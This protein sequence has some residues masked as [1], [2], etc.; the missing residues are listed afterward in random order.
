M[1]RLL[2]KREKVISYLTLA[3]VIFSIGFNFVLAPI[4]KRIDT[5]NKETGIVRFRLKKYLQLIREKS[6]LE[7]K[8]RNFTSGL[9]LPEQGGAGVSAP[10]ALEAIAKDANIRIVDIRPQNTSSRGVYSESIIDVRTEGDIEGYLKFF[11]NVENSLYLLKINKF[12]LSAKP[13]GTLLEGSFSISQLVL[14]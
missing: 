8:Y 9:N 2:T 10:L 5:L 7:N 1:P 11:Y 4:F 6:S 3:V 13:A 14:D 12:Q